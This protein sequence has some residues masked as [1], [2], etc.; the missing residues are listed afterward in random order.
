AITLDSRIKVL[1]ELGKFN[2]GYTKTKLA[3]LLSWSKTDTERILQDMLKSELLV[4]ENISA[5]WFKD[6][7]AMSHQ[8]S[9]IPYLHQINSKGKDFLELASKLDNMAEHVPEPK[10]QIRF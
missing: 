7:R 5:D 6:H 1:K 8:F 9:K 3:H 2:E 10:K 4:A